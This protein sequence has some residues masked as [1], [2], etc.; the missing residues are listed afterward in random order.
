M[1][2]TQITQDNPQARLLVALEAARQLRE[3]MLLI[4]ADFI[5]EL[6]QLRNER[7]HELIGRA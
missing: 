4:D 2:L 7:D 3:S 5:D 6:H 1:G